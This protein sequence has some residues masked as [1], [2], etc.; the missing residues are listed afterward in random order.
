MAIHRQLKARVLRHTRHI[1]IMLK[2]K[3]KYSVIVVCQALTE[4]HVPKL[5]HKNSQPIFLNRHGV[6]LKWISQAKCTEDNI[7]LFG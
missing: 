1:N 2:K 5:H 7:C 6:K 3:S 4:I